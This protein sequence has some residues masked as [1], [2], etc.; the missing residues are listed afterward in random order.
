MHHKILSLS[1]LRNRNAS[2]QARN[3]ALVLTNGCFDLLHVGHT[4][5]LRAARDLGS[6]LAVAVN[7]DHSVRALKG[8]GR[9]L[10]S[11][12]D[13]AEVLAALE[14]VDFVVIFDGDTAAD[15]VSAVQP[16]IYAKGGDYSSSPE[17]VAFP[18]EGHV[19]QKYGGQVVILPYIA[20][21]S[22]SALV[23]AL[24]AGAHPAR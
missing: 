14:S 7:S 24:D 22:T 5:Y 18:P 1:E 16:A 15:V 23:E 9:P 13:R 3:G 4:R 12:D 10:N 2:I 17:D 11:Q 21:H 19:V 20:G 6:A 8:E